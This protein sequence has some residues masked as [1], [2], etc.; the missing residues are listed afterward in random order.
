MIQAGLFFAGG[1]HNTTTRG[2]AESAGIA[3]G[4]LFNYFST[5]E[6]IVAA[7]IAEALQPAN[8]EFRATGN[9]DDRLEADPFNLIWSGFRNLRQFRKF[10]APACETIFGSLARPSPGSPGDSIRV[11][12][13]ELVDEIITTHGFPDRRHRPA[14]RA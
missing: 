6:A 14:T 1:W 8:E 2:I 5:K 7:L 11:D 4:T 9:N 3:T 12:H 10:L 13:L